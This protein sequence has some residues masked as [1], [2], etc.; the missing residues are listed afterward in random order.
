VVWTRTDPLRLG[1][2]CECL[3]GMN[4]KPRTVAD[5]DDDETADSSQ[6]SGPL[7][8]LIEREIDSATVESGS[9][10]GISNKPGQPSTTA[11]DYAAGTTEHAD[12][13]EE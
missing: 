9:V 6:E 10:S 1:T 7:G 4:D 13:R 12:D 3:S 11:T 5:Q 2:P 8:K